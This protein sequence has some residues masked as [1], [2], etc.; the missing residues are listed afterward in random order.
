MRGRSK[1]VGAACAA[2]W[3]KGCGVVMASVSSPRPNV[4]PASGGGGRREGRQAGPISRIAQGGKVGRSEHFQSPF[5]PAR[6]A[7]AAGP[8]RPVVRPPQSDW[9]SVLDAGGTNV[10]QTAMRCSSVR[11]TLIENGLGPH[12]KTRQPATPL[13]CSGKRRLA[14]SPARHPHAAGLPGEGRPAVR[15][16]AGPLAAGRQRNS[17][18]AAHGVIATSRPDA[19]NGPKEFPAACH[20]E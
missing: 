1:G 18:R 13:L 17:P 5:R 16:R 6:L 14:R 12:S 19:G 11:Q 9:G 4:P 3:A 8:G 20:A 7:Q 10:G 15:R 2:R